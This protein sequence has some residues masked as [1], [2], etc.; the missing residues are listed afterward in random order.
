MPAV[1]PD[2]PEY[3]IDDVKAGRPFGLDGM[4]GKGSAIVAE[5]RLAEVCRSLL[6]ADYSDCPSRLSPPD[7][8]TV[9]TLA[10]ELDFVHNVSPIEA[11]LGRSPIRTVL[12]A[13]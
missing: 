4:F 7:S 13:T 11:S 10:G 8:E 9:K 6:A 1:D 2:C 12:G 5:R 3:V